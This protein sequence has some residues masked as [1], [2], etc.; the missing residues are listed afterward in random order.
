MILKLPYG[1]KEL[2]LQI[3]KESPITVLAPRA[4]PSIKDVLASAERALKNPIGRGRMNEAVRPRD[5]VAIIVDNW[6]RP[7]PAH[8]ILPAVVSELEE[9]GVKDENVLVAIASGVHRPCTQSELQKK[10][11][12]EVVERFRVVQHNCRYH[13]AV[14]ASNLVFLGITS[15]STPVWINEEVWKADFKVGVSHIGGNPFAGYTGGGKIIIPGVAGWDTIDWNHKMALSPL[16]KYCA[17]EGNIVREDI[18][19]SARMAALNMTIDVVLDSENQVVNVT[20]GDFVKEHRE[21]LKVCKELYEIPMSERAD[22]T[23]VSANPKHDAFFGSAWALLSADIATKKGG[24]IILAA[25][26][27]LGVAHKG[28]KYYD[29]CRQYFVRELSPQKVLHDIARGA[30]PGFIGKTVYQISRIISEKNLTILSEGVKESEITE[31]GANAASSLDEA[32]EYAFTIHKK[33]ARIA[34]IPFGGITVP[35][36]P[37]G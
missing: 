25:Q 3:P 13:E 15:R 12:K 1:E 10:L 14:P 22:I 6:L 21:G 34:A 30:I 9:S 16:S 5:R 19:E 35:I 18:E 28:C 7:T 17:T 29:A 2:Q 27:P 33:R 23:I 8:Q 32:L 31:M 36:I 26:C 4:R 11:G 24:T 37:S 20:A